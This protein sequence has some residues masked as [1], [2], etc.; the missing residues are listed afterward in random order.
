MS[1]DKKKD[2]CPNDFMQLNRNVIQLTFEF[3]VTED[4]Q[5]SAINNIEMSP[6]STT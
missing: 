4:Q 3:L 2:D 1:F 6:T 5:S